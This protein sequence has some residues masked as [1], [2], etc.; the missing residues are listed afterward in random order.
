VADLD[1]VLGQQVLNIAQRQRKADVEQHREADDLK[2][3][4]PKCSAVEPEPDLT[5]A[6]QA[7]WT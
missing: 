3:E 6:R 2:T 4:V 5:D 1:P 7:H